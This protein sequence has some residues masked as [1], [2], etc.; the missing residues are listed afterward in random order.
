MSDKQ[1][2]YIKTILGLAVLA[3]GFYLMGNVNM[4]IGKLQEYTLLAFSTVGATLIFGKT[5]LL[6]FRFPQGKFIKIVF[7]AL[8]LN[9]LWSTMGGIIIQLI[10]GMSGHHA[11]S[12]VGDF[13][14]LLFIPLML[15]G[16]E[17][18]SITIL[19]TFRKWG[20]SFWLASLCSAII[21]GIIHFQTYYGGNI[22]RTVLQI[23]LIQGGAR[24]IFNYVYQKTRSVW[25]S[26]TVHLLFDLIPL[27]LMPL[28]LHR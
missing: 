23:L 1:K 18:F 7:L 4:H 14:L 25:A 27:T 10:F 9:I 6:W 13:G 28:I 15:V 2:D 16:E 3:L 22:L 8:V 17:L 21:F 19:E 20:W 11:N 26:W 5:W 24:L 12:A